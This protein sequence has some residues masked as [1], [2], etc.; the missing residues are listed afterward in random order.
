[1]GTLLVERD[2]N[3][4]FNLALSLAYDTHCFLRSQAS[5]SSVDEEVTAALTGVFNGLDEAVPGGTPTKHGSHGQDS[6]GSEGVAEPQINEATAAPALAD[7]EDGGKEHAVAA[8]A[9]E[10]A[11]TADEED[12]EEKVTCLNRVTTAPFLL[13]L[14]PVSG[15]FR[16]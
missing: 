6:N 4:V 12:D 9:R 8:E 15:K 1:M 10:E 3:C 5:L 16:C 13:P 14:P 2:S 7:H 11:A